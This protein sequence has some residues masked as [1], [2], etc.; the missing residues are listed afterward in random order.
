[1][2]PE[3]SVDKDGK[4][5]VVK[6]YAP[7]RYAREMVELAADHRT[8]IGGDDGKNTGLFMFVADAAKDLSA[9]TLYAAKVT[10][11]GAANSFRTPRSRLAR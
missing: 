4:A 6:H 1:V 11:T 9:G 8:V 5:K 3:I 2:L 10:Q 7:G